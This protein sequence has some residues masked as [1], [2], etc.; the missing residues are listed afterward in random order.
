LS[1]FIGL[2]AAAA[3]RARGVAVNVISLSTIPFGR[4]FGPEI[5]RFLQRLHEKN[6]VVFHLGRTAWDFDGRNLRLDDGEC[7]E[8]D[9]VVAGI[10][11][12]PRTGLAAS[13]RL[14]IGDGVIVDRHL[15]TSVC[16]IYAAGDIAAY[17]DPLSGR[18][19]RI[20]HW[21]TAQRQ[22]QTVAANMLG[23]RLAFTAV[24]FFWTEQY[25][26]ALRYVGHAPRWDEVRIEGDMDSGSFTARYYEQGQFRASAAVGR[27]V[28]NLEDERRLEGLIGESAAAMNLSGTLE[29]A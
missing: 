3:L 11:V 16:G 5:G 28:E 9:F 2:E 23:A 8:A 20:E 15:Q 21:V 25:G 17:P 13:A 26:V 12:R 22:G 19:M 29:V 7:I 14:A 1:S 6:G 4:L 10:G 18:P 24:P 27:D